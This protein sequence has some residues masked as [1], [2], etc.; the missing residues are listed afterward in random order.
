VALWTYGYALIRPIWLEWVA[1]QKK[2]V[3]ETREVIKVIEV[4]G[5]SVLELKAFRL[6]V[7][8]FERNKPMNRKT[9][10][11]AKITT[12][13]EYQKIHQALEAAQLHHANGWNEKFILET[14]ATSL[15]LSGA[16]L[17]TLQANGVNVIELSRLLKIALAVRML[18]K[19][20]FGEDGKF[21]RVHRLNGEYQLVKFPEYEK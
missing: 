2:I 8:N 12:P 5:A 21:A 19:V 6:V 17:E 13:D 9:A 4:S 7:E 20:Q 15:N 1:T 16:Q 3:V 18:S 14:L 10:V 11:A